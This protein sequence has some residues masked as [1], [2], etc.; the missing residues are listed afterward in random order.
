MYLLMTM[1]VIMITMITPKHFVIRWILSSRHSGEN[2]SPGVHKSWESGRPWQVNFV[3]WRLIFVIPQVGICFMSPFWYLEF[4]GN[5]SICG[6]SV[7]PCTSLLHIVRLR[8][9]DKNCQK[10]EAELFSS[11]VQFNTISLG[12]SYQCSKCKRLTGSFTRRW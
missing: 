11:D 3:G 8:F 7:H 2:I 10:Y 4:G 1:I 6:K 5:V 9:G 12:P